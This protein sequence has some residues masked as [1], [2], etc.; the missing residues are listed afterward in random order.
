MRL[1]SNIA[2][3]EQRR[4][5]WQKDTQRQAHSWKFARA[6]GHPEWRS[7]WSAPVFSGALDAVTSLPRHDK[8]QPLTIEKRQKRQP[9]S[10]TLRA[11]WHR[12]NS[13]GFFTA[14]SFCR[15][16]YDRL[17]PCLGDRVLVTSNPI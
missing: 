4:N 8:S 15:F 1:D 3:P 2:T 7:F 9:H 12:T 16:D 6:I 11:T 13:G 10:K 5:P 14:A 17:S